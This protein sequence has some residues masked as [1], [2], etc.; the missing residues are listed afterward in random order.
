MQG[1]GKFTTISESNFVDRKSELAEL[2][3]HM[4]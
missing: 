3:Y 2:K 1:Y 4:D